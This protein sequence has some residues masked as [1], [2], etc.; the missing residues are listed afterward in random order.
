MQHTINFQFQAPLYALNTAAQR[1]S[2]LSKILVVL[3]GY[4]QLASYF[5]QKF[6]PLQEAGWTIIAPQ[7]LSK[8]YLEGFSGRVGATWMT[9]ENR[10]TDI[11]N[12]THYLNAV[13]DHIHAHY[14]CQ[15]LV[16]LGFSQGAATAC[17][18]I[19]LG[20]CKASR[21]ILW[22]GVFPPDLPFEEVSKALSS[23]A[24]SI[25]YGNNDPF[26]SQ[27]AIDQQLATLNQMKLQAS[28]HTFEGKHD[29]DATLLRE[30]LA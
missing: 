5:V 27:E 14:T 15:E 6:K 18:W 11:L 30:M 19:T 4:G 2:G 24:I 29:I 21:L 9:K 17:R 23:T 26:V 3:H 12:Y 8:F 20:N 7:G 22:A 1:E 13:M 28:I 25:V 16:L 10:D